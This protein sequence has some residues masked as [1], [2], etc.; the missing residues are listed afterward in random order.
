MLYD[1]YFHRD[2]DGRGSA[3][4]ALWF[5]RARGDK[6]RKYT[7]LD[8]AVIP[9]WIKARYFSERSK[10][11]KV[12]IFDFPYHPQATIWYDHHETPFRVPSWGKA[13]KPSALRQWNP[14]YK[15]CCSQTW[16]RL[17]E[18]FKITPP[19][20][21]KELV[22]WGDTIDG[23]MYESAEQAMLG[24]E[25]ALQVCNFMDTPENGNKTLP[26]LVKLMA[27]QSI[28]EIARNPKIK[29]RVQLLTKEKR[30][31]L[32][33]YRNHTKFKDGLAL[34]DETPMRTIR[35]RFAPI[36]IYPEASYVFRRRREGA[37]YHFS[38]GVNPWKIPAHHADI[39][40]LLRKYG[41]G[42][43]KRIGGLEVSGGIAEVERLTQ[44]I[45]GV[46]TRQSNYPSPGRGG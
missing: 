25:P 45:V 27:E 9:E 34:V 8:Y 1:L 33:Y 42:G 43:H 19:A 29:E 13:F 11:A 16:D 3:A 30:Q 38:V 20:Y 21:L 28:E 15:S 24:R 4:I 44:E 31:S 46:L 12:A 10:G 23:A 39:G 2:F 41:G 36:M 5:L 17:A 37:L 18:A 40:A 35:M 22:R 32:A 7:S 26:W 14:E 6:V